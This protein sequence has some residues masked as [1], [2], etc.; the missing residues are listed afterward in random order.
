M[1]QIYTD[2]QIINLI[3]GESDLFE[4]LEAEWA[5]EENDALAIRHEQWSQTKS[6]L[7]NLVFK[8]SFKCT[9]NILAYSA[10]YCVSC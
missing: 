9:N 2:N 7:D 5:M 1:E 6:S 3:Y 8:P 10:A 4:R